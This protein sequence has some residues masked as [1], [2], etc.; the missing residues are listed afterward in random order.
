M[1]S[2]LEVSL[3]HISVGH[4]PISPNPGLFLRE[5][6]PLCDG[7]GV[8]RSAKRLFSLKLSFGAQ[9][10]AGFA[11]H[12]DWRKQTIIASDRS[13]QY[14]RSEQTERQSLVPWQDR[15]PIEWIVPGAAG[16]SSQ[17]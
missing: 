13:I 16:I 7:P 5:F 9:S 11:R 2:S 1:I 12:H 8:E 3:P 15:S 10:G 6:S 4:W 14:K 17:I